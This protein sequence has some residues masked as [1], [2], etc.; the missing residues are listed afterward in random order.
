MNKTVRYQKTRMAAKALACSGMAT[1]TAELRIATSLK[2]GTSS[3][4]YFRFK[5]DL[6]RFYKEKERKS[7]G[8]IKIVET[9]DKEITVTDRLKKKTYGTSQLV[10]S[11]AYKYNSELKPFV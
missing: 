7:C 11:G 6:V 5:P 8:P 2:A 1:V 3:A 9:M 4:T 10:P